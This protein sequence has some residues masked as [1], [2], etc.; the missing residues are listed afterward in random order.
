M[1]FN[2]PRKIVWEKKIFNILQTDILY[3]EIMK[4]TILCSK[5][6]FM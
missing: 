3:K 6:I 4:C 2:V 1:L 5:T